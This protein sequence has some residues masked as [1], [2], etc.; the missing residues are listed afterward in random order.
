[1]SAP[2][3]ILVDSLLT[4][5]L[6]VNLPRFYATLIVAALAA[7]LL[8]EFAKAYP[9]I[10]RHGETQKS[11]I[12]LGFLIGLGFGLVEFALYITVF[13][14]PFYLRLPALLFHASNTSIVAFGISRNKFPR[15]YLLAV[16]L[17]FLNN[18]SAMFGILWFIGGIL[19]TGLSYFIAWYLYRKSSNRTILHWT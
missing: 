9:L 1:M 10:Y 13:K 7:P 2:F 12:A 17:H 15:Y 3:P 18:F 19:A 4:R 16:F 5:T 11:L 14:A 8:E 6:D